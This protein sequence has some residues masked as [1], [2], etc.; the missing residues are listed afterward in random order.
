MGTRDRG[1]GAGLVGWLVG[2]LFLPPARLPSSGFLLL[3]VTRFGMMDDWWKRGALLEC[4][5]FYDF[6]LFRM[7]ISNG[8]IVALF[9]SADNF[10]HK[11]GGLVY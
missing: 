10:F 3:K 7:R 8:M 9:S 1:G 11:G 2:W 4:F 6:F 5:L